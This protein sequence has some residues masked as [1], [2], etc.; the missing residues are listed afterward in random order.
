MV[1]LARARGVDARVGDVQELPFADGAFDCVVAAW[2]LYHVP[3]LD[4]GAR[5]ARARAARRAAG[6]SR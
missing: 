6:S 4:R 5:R 2:M 1:E 3:D